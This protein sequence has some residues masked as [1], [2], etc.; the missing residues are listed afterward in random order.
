MF[1]YPRECT[2][3]LP[4]CRNDIRLLLVRMRGPSG[5]LR[6]VSSSAEVEHATVAC[7][8]VIASGSN[9]GATSRPR[10]ISFSVDSA[11]IEARELRKTLSGCAS[12]D[13][14]GSARHFPSACKKR[15]VTVVALRAAASRRSLL[16][17]GR[18]ERRADPG[19]VT[20]VVGADF[21]TLSDGERTRLR[22]A[23]SVSCF[24]KI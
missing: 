16:F 21:A 10:V 2:N 22:K 23:R 12:V 17:I 14:A 15:V 8:G 19:S 13:R 4:T 3:A 20:I 18:I 5:R 6:F 7:S 24:Q 9:L 11:F 1:F